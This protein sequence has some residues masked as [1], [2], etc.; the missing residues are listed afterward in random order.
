ML[1]HSSNESFLSQ[2]VVSNAMATGTRNT[3]FSRL[4]SAA[5]LGPSLGEIRNSF[6]YMQL[7]SICEW[8]SM[9]MYMCHLKVYGSS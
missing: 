4:L 1:S 7:Q 9:T 8:L 6:V 3:V 5:A 2:Y